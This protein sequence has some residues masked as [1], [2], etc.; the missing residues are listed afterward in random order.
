MRRGHACRGRTFETERHPAQHLSK[1][2]LGVQG[3][4]RKFM[5]VKCS[6]QRRDKGATDK[7]SQE[8]EE[9]V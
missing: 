4:F 5:Y 9:G 6:E 8:N 7:V 3:S 2:G 1:A